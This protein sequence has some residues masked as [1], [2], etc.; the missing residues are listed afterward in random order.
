MSPN[1]ASESGI[2]AKSLAKILLV[3]LFL[4]LITTSEANAQALLDT[5][6]S[7]CTKSDFISHFDFVEAKTV[8]G[9]KDTT[10]HVFVSR[11]WAA[12][13]SLGVDKSGRIVYLRM[14]LP[15]TF[16]DDKANTIRGRDLIKSFV[17]A[18][19]TN[20]ADLPPMRDLADEVFFR[21]LDLHPVD[22]TTKTF[23]DTGNP[24][25][26]YCY[27]LGPG[28]MEKGDSMLPLSAP[29]PKLAPKPSDLYQAIMGKI[30]ELGQIYQYCRLG[31]SNDKAPD[32][33]TI[34]WCET[35]D[36]AY[37]QLHDKPKQK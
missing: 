12:V 1:T 11:G 23:A 31:F 27:K 17:V 24:I 20:T 10:L 33:T 34:L 6:F 19:V 37:W 9:P 22:V 30:P 35:W 28:P 14:V 32:G 7:Q 15:R 3:L 25:P 16:I 4:T 21:D 29:P 13:L 18:S 2:R 36:E 5:P 8:E 26:P